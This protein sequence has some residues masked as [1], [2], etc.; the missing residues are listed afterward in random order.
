[1]YTL[2][3]M[4]EASKTG[5][6][7]IHNDMRYSERRGFVDEELYPWSG[8]QFITLNELLDLD[9]WRVLPQITEAERTI[10]E[11]IDP[12]YNYIIRDKDG[13]LGIYEK[14]P[15]K[16]EK[17]WFDSELGDS[18]NFHA[19]NHLFQFIKWEDAE[20]TLIADLLK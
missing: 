9:G 20:P 8:K 10:L 6:T 14:K 16:C 12:K 7:Y 18:V 4:N 19:F 1:M 13:I 3:M 15:Q 11:A 17:W 2:Q 5:L